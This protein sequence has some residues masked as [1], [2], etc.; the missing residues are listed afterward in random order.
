SP[1]QLF[2]T[3]Q[4]RIEAGDYAPGAWLPTERALAQEFSVDRSGIR[5]A[6]AQLEE[7]GLITREPGRRPWVTQ[8]GDQRTRSVD[9]IAGASPA[10]KPLRSIVAVLPQHP[11]HPASLFILHGINMALRV[12]DAPYRLQVFDTNGDSDSAAVELEKRTLEAVL[13][14]GAA[15]VIIWQM[16]SESTLPQ[17]IALEALGVPVVFIDR[18]PE[19][20][21]CD[22]VGVDNQSAI[23]D[24]VAYLHALG[25]TRIAHL[26]TDEPST[27]V[28]ERREAFA[29]AMTALGMPP[30]PDWTFVLMRKDIRYVRNEAAVRAAFD[31]FFGS[32]EPPTAVITMND[33]LAHYF[34]HEAEA[35]GKTV[36]ADFSIIGFDDVERHSPRPATLTTLHQPFDKMGRR[37]AMLLLERLANPGKD[38]EK[39]HIL[40]SAPLVIRSTCRSLENAHTD[41]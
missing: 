20:H 37:A 29:E 3:I 9:A 13:S 15:G 17:L 11:K 26:T 1:Q 4:K 19:G 7:Q 6:L 39:Q 30:R 25:H 33:A 21:R 40:M 27:A 32:P 2:L 36:P 23:E 24:A 12:A 31:Q 5:S 41:V 16:G 8:R 38:R 35:R 14:E 34:M 22:Y 10:P 28:H 18:Y